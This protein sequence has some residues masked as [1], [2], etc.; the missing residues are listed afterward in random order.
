MVRNPWQFTVETGMRAVMI[1]SDGVGPLL[2]QAKVF[3]ARWLVDEFS[4]GESVLKW[5]PALQ[6][7][8]ANG[9]VKKAYEASPPPRF[10]LYLLPKTE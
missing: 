3:R 1:P 10:G 2:E 4:A 9:T 7:L 8:L 5:R 6:A